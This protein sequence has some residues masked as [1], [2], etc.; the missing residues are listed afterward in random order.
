MDS[1]VKVATLNV[2][3]RYH[4]WSQRRHL[5]VSEIVDLLPDLVSLQELNFPLGQGKWIR[6]QIN[7]RLSG[8]PRAPYRLLQKRLFHVIQGYYEGVGILTRLPVISYDSLNL[9]Y[10]GRVALRANVSLATGES[11][12]FVATH[13]HSVAHDHEARLEQVLLLSGW[14]NDVSRV[15]LQVI[16][17]DFN[18][19]PGGLAIR[20]M[21]QTYRS[22]LEEARGFEPVATFPTA[23]VPNADGWSGCLDYIF[24]SSEIAVQSAAIFANKSHEEEKDL[25]PSDHVGLTAT[26]QIEERAPLRSTPQQRVYR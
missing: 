24:I 17:G 8:S 1:L 14:L 3:N 13:L 21:K 11:L 23:L 10:E 6:N 2:H 15:P 4:R 19:L 9:G 18:E 16:A 7:I 20:Q 25:Y 26:L 5:I 22:A 12:D